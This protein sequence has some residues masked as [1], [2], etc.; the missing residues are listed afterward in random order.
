MVASRQLPVPPL[1]ACV[2]ANEDVLLL[3]RDCM[4]DAGYRAVTFCSPVRYGS[5]PVVDF[6]T[7]LAPDLALYCAS[8]P[9]EASWSEF[10]RLAREV[11]ECP[12]LATT[13]N[14][15]ALERLVGPAEV[16]EV[17]ASAHDLEQ[18]VTV[19]CDRL[20]AALPAR[21][22]PNGRSTVTD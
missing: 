2:D 6:V 14:K 7:Y 19:V 22:S 13:T 16:L 21:G 17:L 1:I 15:A 9:Y 12:V 18:L 20:A 4:V 5:Q 3:L 10:L 8:P 11:P